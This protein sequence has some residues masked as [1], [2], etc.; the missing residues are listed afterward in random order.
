MDVFAVDVNI[1]IATSAILMLVAYLPVSSWLIFPFSLA[2]ECRLRERPFDFM[3]VVGGGGGGG[4]GGRLKK[5][6]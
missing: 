5:I 6:K 3:W 1:I 4:G 2:K